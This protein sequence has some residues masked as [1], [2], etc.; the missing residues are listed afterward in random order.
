MNK[1]LTGF[2][3]FIYYLFTIITCGGLYIYKIVMKKAIA[4]M[5]EK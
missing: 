1:K 3:S 5:N 4:E 2:E